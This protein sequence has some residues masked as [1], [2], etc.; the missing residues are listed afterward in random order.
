MEMSSGSKMR[1]IWYQIEVTVAEHGG[2]DVGDHR[3]GL[4]M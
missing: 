3:H 4:D 1:I 2:R